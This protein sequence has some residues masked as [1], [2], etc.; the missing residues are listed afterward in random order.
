MAVHRADSW[1]DPWGARRLYED[2]PW[3]GLGFGNTGEV[4]TWLSPPTAVGMAVGGLL[5]LFGFDV[6]DNTVAIARLIGTALTLCVLAWLCLRP[7]GRTPIRGAALAFLTLVVQGQSFSPGM[8]SGVCPCS[9]R[10]A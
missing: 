3:L 1:G 2:R 8:C 4:R 9:Q 6:T 10:P 7:W 5:G